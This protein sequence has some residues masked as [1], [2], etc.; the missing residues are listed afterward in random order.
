ML[1]LW[2]ITETPSSPFCSTA[3][4]FSLVTSL[5]W[6]SSLETRSLR[7][8]ASCS[9]EVR[10]ML[11]SKFAALPA[12]LQR[13]TRCRRDTCQVFRFELKSQLDRKCTWPSSAPNRPLKSAS[14]TA[15]TSGLE[16]FASSQVN[17]VVQSNLNFRSSSLL[18]PAGCAKLQFSI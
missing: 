9:G 2:L 1:P 12:P 3:T 6:P 11:A 18:S 17:T 16:V 10:R 13:W 8:A 5:A 7:F 4:T 15:F 14:I